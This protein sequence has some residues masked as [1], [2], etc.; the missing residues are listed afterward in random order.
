MALAVLVINR[1]A[2]LEEL[3]QPRGIER[4]V[5]AHIEQCLGLV[6]QEP[7]VAVGRRDQ[8]VARGGGDGQGAAHLLFGLVEQRAQRLVIEPVEDQHLRAAEQRGV[9]FETGI[10]GGRTDQG[11]GAVLDEGQETVLLGAVEA[12]YLIH[13]Q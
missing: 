10:L 4:L 5:E 8:R 12:V 7:P 2:A 9:E 3:R 11:D 13:Q 6:E 1:H